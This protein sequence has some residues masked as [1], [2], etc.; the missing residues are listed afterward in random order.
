M[1]V[2]DESSLLFTAVTLSIQMLMNYIHYISIYIKYDKKYN[3]VK[4][5]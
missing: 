2:E 4:N 3:T 1:S 5:V